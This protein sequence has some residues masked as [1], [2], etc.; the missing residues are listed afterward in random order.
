VPRNPGGVAVVAGN[1]PAF[2]LFSALVW[3]T[4]APGEP[5]DLEALLFGLVV[6][7]KRPT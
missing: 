4:L 7:G 1:L 2:A 6:F 3:R 5:M